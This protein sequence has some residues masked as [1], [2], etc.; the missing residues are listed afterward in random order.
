MKKGKYTAYENI[1]ID[2]E[3]TIKQVKE[4]D[5][6]GNPKYVDGIW[7]YLKTME[8]AQQDENLNYKR[9]QTKSPNGFKPTD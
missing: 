9:I 4:Q 5:T 6:S 3:T 1:K 8:Y 7:E 2:L